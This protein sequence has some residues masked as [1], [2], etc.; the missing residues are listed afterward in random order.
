MEGFAKECAVV[1]H[2][3]LHKNEHDTLVVDPAAEL[4]EPLVGRP[5]SKTI[6]GEFFADSIESHRDL[7]LL[8][9]QWVNV[10]RWEMRPRAPRDREVIRNER[11][12][13]RSAASAGARLVPS[14]DPGRIPEALRHWRLR[15]IRLLRTVR[16]AG[17]RGGC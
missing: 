13:E 14:R 1:T 11:R 6:I 9:N 4:D 8:I 3:R 16:L 2:Y 5:T 15:W 17:V 7:P 12:A 10:V